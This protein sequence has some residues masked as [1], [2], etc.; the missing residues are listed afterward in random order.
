[1]VKSN[2]TQEGY[3]LDDAFIQKIKDHI[4][5]DDFSVKNYKFDRIRGS[6]IKMVDALFEYLK[7]NNVNVVFISA[8]PDN[9]AGGDSM[10][11]PS[12]DGYGWVI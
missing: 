4:A 9:N 3:Q 11:S 7:D 5:N 1:M 10:I 12:E 2:I 8:K 6:L